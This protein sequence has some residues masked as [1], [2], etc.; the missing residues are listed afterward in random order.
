MEIKE[1]M[2]SDI[3]K[4][5][6]EIEE[7]MK[8]EN[9]DIDALTHEVEELEARKA[10]IEAEVETRKKEMEEALKNSEEVDSFEKEEVRKS[11]T[12]NELINSAEY[13]KAYADYIIKGND[14][15]VR[16]LLT[17]N[18][19][20]DNVGEGDGTI[21]V[22]TYLANKIQ[23][24]WEKDEITSRITKSALKGNLKIGFELSADG[25]TVHAE[26]AEAPA[27]EKLTLGVVEIIPETIKKW[28]KVSSEQYDMGGEEFMEYIYDEIAYRIVKKMAEIILDKI[29]ASPSASTATAVGV[30]AL[31]QAL[32]AT[33]VVDAEALLGDEADEIVLIMNRST[34]AT[35]K[36]LMV[37][38]GTNVGDVFD[39]KKVIFSSHLPA[40]ATASSGDAYMIVGDLKGVQGNFPNGDEVKF[41]FDEKSLAEDD[42]VKVVG[43]LYGGF[44]VIREGA[45]AQVTKP[46]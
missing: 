36:G 18:A 33:T 42:L 15:E 34:Y 40:Y 45:F 11:M 6:L 22:P 13:R 10:E 25:A 5:S 31:A 30:G 41:I 23:T 26:G 27:E 16:R 19:D 20:P 28:I 1:M 43:R 37:S 2:M 44:G 8:A 17:E 7:E 14:V 32:G 39:G 3:E 21:P 46:E 29:T 4:R 12:L 35:L 24:N 38:S 9:A